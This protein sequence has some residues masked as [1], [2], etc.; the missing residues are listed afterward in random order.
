MLQVLAG[1]AEG[2]LQLMIRMVT[3]N[4][5]VLLH[6]ISTRPAFRL[7]DR[8]FVLRCANSQIDVSLVDV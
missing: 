6:R 3:K 8:G 2:A 1:D 4:E 5:F 7:T